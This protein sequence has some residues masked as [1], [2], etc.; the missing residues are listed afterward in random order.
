MDG[1]NL[2]VLHIIDAIDLLV[3]ETCAPD[4]AARD[5]TQLGLLER[6][7]TIDGNDTPT[8]TRELNP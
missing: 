6:M 3:K 1:R 7:N 2:G 4:L 5:V 8:V